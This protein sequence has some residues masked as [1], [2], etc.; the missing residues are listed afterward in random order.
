MTALELKNN[1]HRMV[2]ET[3]DVTVLEQISILF[4][5]LRD[6][7]DA[8]SGISEAEN[9]QILKG[10]EDLRNG[11]VNSNEEV[12]AKVRAILNQL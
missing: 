4:S 12:R 2:V 10:L 7:K 11:H 5:A 3:D 1:L 6:E 8:E 9:A